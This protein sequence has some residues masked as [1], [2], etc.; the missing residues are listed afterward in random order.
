[1]QKISDITAAILVGG[2]GTRLQKVIS[3]KPKALACV[4][5]KPFLAYLL[6]QLASAEIHRVVLCT[7]HMGNEVRACFGDSYCSLSVIYSNE[8]YPLGTGGA[9]RLALP[10]L[11]S[12][13]VLVMNGDSYIDADLRAFVDWFSENNSDA[14]LLLTRVSDTARFGAVRINK[15]KSIASFREK[16]ENSGSGWINAG[17][18]LIRKSLI[19]SI[20]EGIFY[21]LERQF[22]PSLVNKGLF[23]FCCKRRF[24]DIGTAESYAAA[25]GFFAGTK[26]RRTRF[27][28]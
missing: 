23:G 25:E 20:P 9:L 18:Y 14:A 1:M 24:I 19:A 22:F 11:S 7:G 28:T 4:S 2:F 8:S 6:D 27:N 13:I 10:H 21:S 5:G 3:D 17:I 16:S 26:G 15:D 12:D